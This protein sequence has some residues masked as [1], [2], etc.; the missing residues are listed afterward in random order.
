VNLAA[1]VEETIQGA[2]N[3]NMISKGA[4][5]VS[6]W[7][8]RLEV[9]ELSERAFWKSSILVMKCAKWLSTD[10]YIHY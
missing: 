5:I 4:E 1:V 7:H 2:I 9:S 6:T 3:T 8:K 10:C